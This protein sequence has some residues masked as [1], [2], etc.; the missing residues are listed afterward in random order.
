MSDNNSPNIVTS[1]DE[2]VF[3]INPLKRKI[4]EDQESRSIETQAKNRNR[5]FAGSGI[6]LVSYDVDHDDEDSQSNSGSSATFSEVE[7]DE[8][9][10]SVDGG[11]LHFMNIDGGPVTVLSSEHIEAAHESPDALTAEAQS[12]PNTESTVEKNRL[13]PSH[14]FLLK[15][16]TDVDKK[17]AEV[18]LPP[19]PT[20][21]CSMELLNK[22]ETTVRRMQHDISFDPN[23]MIQDNKSFRNPRF[24]HC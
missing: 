9:N 6:N 20:E 23:R 5:F 7:A 1:E 12:A 18:T 24:E 4:E 8:S 2:S 21:L 17:A 10:I 3:P 19:E 11:P 14:T 13:S 15:E 16:E 22:V